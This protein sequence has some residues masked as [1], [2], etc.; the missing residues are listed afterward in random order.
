MR[1]ICG[2]EIYHYKYI[3]NRWASLAQFTVSATPKS[4]TEEK[5]G[6]NILSS[7]HLGATPGHFPVCHLVQLKRAHLWGQISF[8]Y[9]CDKVILLV[10]SQ[11]SSEL[12]KS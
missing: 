10:G 6:C 5:F 4:K 2:G 7:L 12:V 1:V 3:L 9:L 8:Y 11:N